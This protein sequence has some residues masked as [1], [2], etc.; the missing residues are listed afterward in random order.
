MSPAA[1]ATPSGT[2]AATST[3]TATAT[4]TSATAPTPTRTSVPPTNTATSTATRTPT[5]TATATATRTPTPTATPTPTPTRTPVNYSL[6]AY[7]T[8]NVYILPYDEYAV[9]C[10]QLSPQNVPFRIYF[11]KENEYGETPLGYVDDNGI[12]GGD[13]VHV[14]LDYDD[15]YGMGVYMEVYVDGAFVADAYVEANIAIS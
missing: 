7:F 12:G 13:C 5:R 3:L 1:S 15:V 10:Y 9:L 2:P 14:P 6:S 8:D 11:Y 4:G